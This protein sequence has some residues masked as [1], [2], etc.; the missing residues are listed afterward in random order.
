M[1]GVVVRVLGGSVVEIVG[2]HVVQSAKIG[3]AVRILNLITGHSSPKAAF[4]Q[5]FSNKEKPP[6]KGTRAGEDRRDAEGGHTQWTITRETGRTGSGTRGT[7]AI[8]TGARASGH[9]RISPPAH[10]GAE[11]H[12]GEPRHQRP[13]HAQAQQHRP[14]CADSP[15]TS[16]SR[17]ASSIAASPIT[18]PNTTCCIQ[19]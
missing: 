9:P 4:S 2:G 3:R 18:A 14:P 15:Y 10:A 12:P 16:R 6:T 19:L 8:T 5:A 17:A 13:A 11:R 1:Q 7:R